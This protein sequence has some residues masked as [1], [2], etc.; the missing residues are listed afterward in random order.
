M[1]G[2]F[3]EE[4][5]KEEEKIDPVVYDNNEKEAKEKDT[6]VQYGKASYYGEKYNGRKTANGEIF[7]DSKFTAAHKTLAFGTF[8]K[9]TNAKNNR[10][11]IVRVNDRGPFVKGRILDLSTAAAKK[12]GSISDGVWDVEIEV[13]DEKE[14]ADAENNDNYGDKDETVEKNE[15]DGYKPDFEKLYQS[16][17]KQEDVAR[18]KSFVKEGVQKKLDI[19][20]LTAENLVNTAKKYLGVPYRTG[21]TS[22]DGMDCTGLT[23]RPFV[24]WGVDIPREG[25]NQARYGKFIT[26]KNDLKPGDLVFFTRTYNTK[27]FITHAG[28]YVG[29]KKFINA[30]S[31]YG[32]VMED[33]IDDS[34]WKQFYIFGVRYF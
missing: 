3:Y 18:L 6:F 19:K 27:N 17:P 34:Y 8:L 24:E 16:L 25:Y 26:S 11:V 5:H 1:K 31:Y 13:I 20:N 23:Y 29:N 32:R 10:S 28:I 15:D 4:E 7:D 33:I 9:V 22:F 2:F 12:I 21:G 14:I 30:N